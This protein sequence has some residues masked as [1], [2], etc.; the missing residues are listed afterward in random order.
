MRIA[1]ITGASSG[2]GSRYAAHV[3]KEEKNIDEIWLIARRQDRLQQVAMNLRHPS[4][5]LPMDL[6]DPSVFE[7]LSATLRLEAVEVG[8]LIN[9]AGF[10][11]IGNYEQVDRKDSD[12][13]I[14]LNCRAAVDITLTCLPYMKAGDRI[15]QICSTAGF[16]PFQQLNVYAASK[17]FLYSY[18]RALRTELLPRKIMVTAVCPYWIKDT[19]FIGIAEQTSTKEKPGI[20][21]FPGST[22][23]EDVVRRS[24]HASRRGQAVSTPGVVCTLHRIFAKLLPREVMM[25]LWEGIRRI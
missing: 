24:L 1:L 12:R 9:C 25:G 4:R 20:K 18:T 16:S 11:K 10:G 3:D 13:M 19:E 14:D 21:S 5:I 23:A 2:I 22:K 6:T 17:A 15:M 7:P 8:L